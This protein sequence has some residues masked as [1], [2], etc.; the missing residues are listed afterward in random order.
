MRLLGVLTLRIYAPLDGLVTENATDGYPA[1]K[2]VSMSETFWPGF[3]NCCVMAATLVG[4]TPSMI[5][6]S[7]TE[8]LIPSAPFAPTM[9]VLIVPNLGW[10]SVTV[11]SSKG[12]GS[13]TEKVP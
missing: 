10:S 2:E 6:V 11:K 1:N 3:E 8:N 4:E 9:Y 5:V 7:I 12:I 13:R